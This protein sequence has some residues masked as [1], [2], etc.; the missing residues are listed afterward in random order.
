MKYP[1]IIITLFTLVSC[2]G[3]GGGGSSSSSGG[4]S[5]FFPAGLAVSSPTAET[6][7]SLV[8][9]MKS[10]IG[11]QAATQLDPSENVDIKIDKLTQLATGASES[12]Q[13]SLPEFNGNVGP[14]CFGPQLYY[15]NHL[16]WTSGDKLGV[17]ADNSAENLPSGDLGIWEASQSGE[18]CSAAKVNSDMENIAA[19]VDTAL[20]LTAAVSCILNKNGVTLGVGDNEDVESD[21]NTA[22]SDADYTVVEATVERNANSS[23]GNEVYTIWIQIGKVDGSSTSDFLTL[24]L[25]HSPS[26]LSESIFEGVFSVLQNKTSEQHDHGFSLA[27]KQTGSELNYQLRFTDFDVTPS[28]SDMFDSSSGVLKIDQDDPGGSNQAWDNF[29]QTT[30][31]RNIKTKATAF[32]YVW[33]AGT[34]DRN[35][36]MFNLWTT[37]SG[38]THS[39]LAYYGFAEK[40]DSVAGSGPTGGIEGFYCSWAGPENSGSFDKSGYA[41]KQVIQTNSSGIFEATESKITYA[42]VKSCD[43]SLEE[44]NTD[45]D[46]SNTNK[47]FWYWTGN[48]NDS[49][50]GAGN[51]DAAD[52]A[53]PAVTNDLIEI[54]TDTDYD[55]SN[56]PEAPVLSI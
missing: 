51:W 54:S 9:Q 3:G 8:S 56:I 10:F 38:S 53:Q 48:V 34:G 33:Q 55:A 43:M 13:F 45:S 36:R 49:P 24:A 30:V 6:S 31:T 37:L 15:V 2:G 35:S 4:S 7:T 14:S 28:F 25:T 26:S 52:Y 19:K 20:S 39:G 5:S 18:A 46:N 1:Y 23:S 17:P 12:C 27:Y 50:G 29:S 16:D 41:Q 22:L 44:E 21:L 32:N 42:P 40:F 11:I 47:E